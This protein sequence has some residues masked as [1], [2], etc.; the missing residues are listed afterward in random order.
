M[1]EALLGGVLSAELANPKEIC[2]G[3]PLPQRRQYLS[4]KYGILTS[5]DNSDTIQGA[6]LVILAIK[7]QDLPAV[8]QKLGGQLQAEQAA[9]SIVA[10]AKMSTLCEGLGHPAVIR[11]MP[12]TPAQIGQGM[13]L[14]TCSLGLPTLPL[15][16]CPELVAGSDYVE[17]LDKIRA[18]HEREAPFALRWSKNTVGGATVWGNPPISRFQKGD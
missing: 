9:L 1:A 10:G 12:N 7:P 17:T 13:S 16:S 6:E 3:E 2:V 8:C 15:G 11:V 4:Q 14:W 18:H 5:Q